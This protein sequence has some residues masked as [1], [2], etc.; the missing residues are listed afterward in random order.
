MPR[1]RSLVALDSPDVDLGVLN[2][3]DVSFRSLFCSICLSRAMAGL[4]LLIEG[5]KPRWRGDFA[6]T[7]GPV[8]SNQL[9]GI[10][11]SRGSDAGQPGTTHATSDESGSGMLDRQ[12]QPPTGNRCRR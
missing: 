3:A 6:A 8:R 4:L 7:L 11:V 9:A 2:V 12:R 5:G 10:S 1:S